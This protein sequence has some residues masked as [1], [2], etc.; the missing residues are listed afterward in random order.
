MRRCAEGAKERRDERGKEKGIPKGMVR[1]KQREN[2]GWL[3]RKGRWKKSRRG[4]KAS[5]RMGM[6]GEYGGVKRWERGRRIGGWR[7]S[8]GGTGRRRGG[9]TACGWQRSGR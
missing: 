3:K 7:W 8:A 1:E 5:I 6:G 9:R 2:G 4:G